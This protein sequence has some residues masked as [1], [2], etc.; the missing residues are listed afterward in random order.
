MVTKVDI[1]SFAFTNLG[2]NPVSDIDPFSAEP[3]VIDASKKYDLLLRD[4]LSSQ[5]WRFATFTRD[6]NKLA[7][8]PPVKEFSDAFQLPADY[9]NLEQTRPKVRFRLFENMIYVNSSELQIDYRAIV[10]ESKFPPWFSLY[11]VYVLTENIAMEITQQITIQEKWEKKA[12]KKF[13]Q[14]RYNDS[15]QQTGDV[16]VSDDILSSHLGSIRAGRAL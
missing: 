9:L 7:A 13:L 8:D 6:L 10:D 15:Q 1:V 4:T 14:A 16:I 11:M 5:S 3:Q 12:E 2:K